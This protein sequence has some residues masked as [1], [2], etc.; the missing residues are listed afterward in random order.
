MRLVSFNVN[1]LRARLHQLE[2]LI[3]KHQPDV[4]GLQETK[5]T[6]E[7]FPAEAIESLGY[8]VEYFGQKSHYGVAMLSKIP[9]D[10]CTKGFPEADDTE[11]RRFI[12]GTFTLSDGS[13][14]T[15][16]NGY[17]PQGESNEHPTKYPGKE[18]YYQSLQRYLNEHCS[19]QDQV[20]VMG[21]VNVAP[22]DMDI[23]IGEDNRKRWIKTGKCSFLPEEREWL[24]TLLGWGLTDTYRQQHPENQEEY[25]WFDYRT[26]GFDRDPKRGLRIDLILTSPSLTEKISGAGI[27]YEMR[28]ME[29][30]SDHCP[31]WTDLSL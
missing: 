6:D 5:V 26:K 7:L 18:A 2:E 21:D 20:V 30:P 27:D 17:F 29:K 23:G 9:F 1:S 15:V 14:L 4:I 8:H 13:K 10:K 16:L 19:V 25:S 28:A 31:I 12:T 22:Q 11:Q 24:Q 3:A